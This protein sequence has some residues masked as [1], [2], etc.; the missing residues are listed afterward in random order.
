VAIKARARHLSI[1]CGPEKRG[2]E[3]KPS[4]PRPKKLTQDAVGLV[5]CWPGPRQTNDI[6]RYRPATIVFAFVSVFALEGRRRSRSCLLTE[7]RQ[8]T[9]DLKFIIAGLPCCSVRLYILIVFG[10]SLAQRK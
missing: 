7:M 6:Y 9:N 8:M 3:D 2:T 4:E 10:S 5:G 1:D